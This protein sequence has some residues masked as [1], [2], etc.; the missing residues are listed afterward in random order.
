[1]QHR[2][3]LTAQKSRLTAAKRYRQVSEWT[4]DEHAGPMLHTL[5]A[6]NYRSRDDKD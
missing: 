3:A 2:N 1:M 6:M 5:D 4:I